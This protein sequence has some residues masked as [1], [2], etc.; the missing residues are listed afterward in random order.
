MYDVYVFRARADERIQIRLNSDA[1]DPV[2][3]V[4]RRSGVAFEELASN[5]DG[6][7]GLNS[8]ILFTAPRP[9]TTSSAPPPCPPMARA[10]T[11]CR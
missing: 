4:G 5:D 1:F 2:L 8:R 11:S 6:D 7:D 10:P 9:A 3:Y